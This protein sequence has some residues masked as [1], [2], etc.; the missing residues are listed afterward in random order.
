MWLLIWTIIFLSDALSP[1]AQQIKA[2]VESITNVQTPVAATSTDTTAPS[3]VVVLP[4]VPSNS[5]VTQIQGVSLPQTNTT[6]NPAQLV[7]VR[8][9]T[10]TPQQQLVA[11]RSATDTPQQQLVAV[12]SATDTP[13]QQLVAVRSATDTPQPQQLVAVRSATETAQQQQLVQTE[14]GSIYGVSNVSQPTFFSQQVPTIVSNTSNVSLAS[15]LAPAALQTVSHHLAAEEQPADG[16]YILIVNT[17]GEKEQGK[18]YD[19]GGNLRGDVIEEI[20][21]PD[22]TTKR[23]VKVLFALSLP[24]YN[25]C[26]MPLPLFQK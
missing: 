2:L 21:E 1:A 4:S 26:Y 16:S 20:T 8:S 18:V 19:F 6:I 13:Q 9:A 15:P 10:D 3:P 22:G 7:T 11:V 24:H 25:L 23:L 17:S 12:R 5:S 14:D